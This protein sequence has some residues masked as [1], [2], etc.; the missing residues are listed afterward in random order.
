MTY[1][2]ASHLKIKD[3]YG[4][5][6]KTATELKQLEEQHRDYQIYNK[7]KTTLNY[8]F[9]DRAEEQAKFRS[10]GAVDQT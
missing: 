4:D 7:Q 3:A 1:R 5:N 10:D 8:L 6:L 9:Y 2:D